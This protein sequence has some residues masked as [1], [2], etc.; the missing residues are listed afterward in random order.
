MKDDKRKTDVITNHVYSWLVIKIF[1]VFACIKAGLV[2]LTYRSSGA[3]LALIS[4]SLM[5]N[6]P[7]H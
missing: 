3:D 4:L 1:A 5:K 6:W 7:P 2:L